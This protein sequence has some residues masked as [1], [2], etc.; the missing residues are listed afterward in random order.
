MDG[1]TPLHYA[2]NRTQD[3]AIIESLRNAGADVRE[4]N[5]AGNRPVDLA[6]DIRGS[7]AYW[8]LVVPEGVLVPGQT[9]D[10]GLDS[11]DA[12]WDDG[13]P[14]EVWSVTA[15]TA[16]QRV[17]IEM[18]SDDVDAVLRVLAN[19]GTDVATDDDG[20]SGT[21]AR[22]DFRA[23]GTGDYLVLAKSYEAG[24]TGAYSLRVR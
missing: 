15:R 10:S 7:A 4:R 9:V 16:G 20:G 17:V 8:R 22:V 24:E 12:V 2:A 13:V 11:L 3:A 23:T 18:N 14:Y 6:W 19:D 1:D 21:N 5:D